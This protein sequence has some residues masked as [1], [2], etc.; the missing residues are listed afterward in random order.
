MWRSEI[1]KMYS[2]QVYNTPPVS[3]QK[4]SHEDV[5]SLAVKNSGFTKPDGAASQLAIA[6]TM[7][8]G[9]MSPVEEED[10]TSAKHFWMTANGDIDDYSTRPKEG[11]IR[12]VDRGATYHIV[13]DRSNTP[14]REQ[15]NSFKRMCEM[16]EKNLY[17]DMTHKVLIKQ[18]DS[19][20][21]ITPNKP[22][23]E[24]FSKIDLADYTKLINKNF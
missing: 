4:R 22:I 14:T 24:S 2:E 9:A 10:E 8:V 19:D 15:W 12:V 18:N 13:Y 20:P 7:G 1:S 21:N 6:S 16:S 5:T 11:Y 23:K 3:G 17:D